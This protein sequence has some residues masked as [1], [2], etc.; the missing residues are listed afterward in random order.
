MEL[1]DIL[2]YGLLAGA[3]FLMMRHGGCCG[4]HS[5]GHGSDKKA[6]CCSGDPTCKEAEDQQKRPRE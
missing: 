1:Q 2:Q 6:G 3:M 5:H 4:G